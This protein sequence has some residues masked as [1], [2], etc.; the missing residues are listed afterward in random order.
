MKSEP[1]DIDFKDSTDK[2]EEMDGNVLYGAE[3]LAY[4]AE[5]PAGIEIFVAYMGDS[6][7]GPGL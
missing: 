2:F 7:S 3:G 1:D 4:Q 6:V 5:C